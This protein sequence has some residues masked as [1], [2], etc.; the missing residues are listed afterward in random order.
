MLEQSVLDVDYFIA[1]GISLLS[2][3][4]A[5]EGSFGQV[6]RIKESLDAIAKEKMQGIHYKL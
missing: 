1:V 5:F 3:K 4:A 6:A 2:G